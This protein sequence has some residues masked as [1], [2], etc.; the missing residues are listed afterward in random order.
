M[1][2]DVQMSI[3]LDRQLREEFNGV[4]SSMHRPAAQLARELIRNFVKSQRKEPSDST[5]KAM[6]QEE[7]GDTVE[8]SGFDDM[9]AKCGI[10]ADD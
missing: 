7:E 3:K 4:A 5:L 9:L 8:I 10:D 1:S 2:N 6:K